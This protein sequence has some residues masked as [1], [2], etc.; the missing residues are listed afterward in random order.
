MGRYGADCYVYRLSF[1]GSDDFGNK[2]YLLDD[3]KIIGGIKTDNGRDRV[4]PIHPEIKH[5]VE[6]R[7]IQAMER[8]HS[9]RLFNDPKGHQSTKMTYDMFCVKS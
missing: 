8:Y 3:N 1:V 4:V 9:D 7:Y 5:L 2:E 6:K